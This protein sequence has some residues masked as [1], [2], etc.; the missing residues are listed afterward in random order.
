MTKFKALSM[1]EILNRFNSNSKTII[2]DTRVLVLKYHHY[3]YNCFGYAMNYFDW[4]DL[5]NFYNLEDSDD[6]FDA[7]N[8]M[9]E[10]CCD[11]LEENY[12]L[13][14]VKDA[15]AP[16]KKNEYLIAF[17]VGFDDFHFARLLSDGTWSHKPGG[18]YI[19]EMGE[20]EFYDAWCPDREY[21]YVSNIGYFVVDRKKKFY[22]D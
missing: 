13:R 8:D 18:N 7:L 5:N 4:L 11:E 9:F 19:R 22:K 20:E 15:N 6:D 12:G 3:N 21:P 10:Q 1:M 17:R 16:L 14:R 2:K